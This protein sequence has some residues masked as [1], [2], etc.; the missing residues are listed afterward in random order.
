M[1]R[2]KMVEVARVSALVLLVVTRLAAGAGF[3]VAVVWLV[4]DMGILA[5]AKALHATGT[6]LF[7]W[8]DV[9]RPTAWLTLAVLVL[10]STKAGSSLLV[11]RI[12]D[13][14][15]PALSFRAVLRNGL[16]LT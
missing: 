9:I 2:R 14:R 4:R 8:A 11:T 16:S 3:M 13:H 15:W 12:S 7:S 5:L 10:S 6:D 1:L